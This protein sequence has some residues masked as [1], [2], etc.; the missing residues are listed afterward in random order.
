MVLPN[1]LLPISDWTSLG[2]A[3]VCCPQASASYWRG[4][5][6]RESLQRVYGI[7]YP[8]TKKL[9]VGADWTPR[10]SW[11]AFGDG[12]LLTHPGRHPQELKQLG[13]LSATA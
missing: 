12:F 3:L 2:L 5:A 6:D 7:S 10:A 13:G 8:D 4:R 11:R 1:M 9:K